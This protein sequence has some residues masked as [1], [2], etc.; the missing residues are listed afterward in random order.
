MQQPSLIVAQLNEALKNRLEASSCMT[1]RLECQLAPSFLLAFHGQRADGKTLFFWQLEPG[2]HKLLDRYQKTAAPDAA[3]F[4]IDINL[5]H[6]SFIY[7]IISPQQ[8]AAQ[9]DKETREQNDE[10]AR[11]LQALKQTLLA[12]NIPYGSE[13]AEQV[14]AALTHGALCYNH[15]DYCG[16]GLEKNAGGNYVYAMIWDGW[17]ELVHTFATRQ[18]FVAWLAGQSDASLSRVDE[19]DTWVWNNQVIN[20]QRLEEFVAWSQSHKQDSND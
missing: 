6:N 13:L 7:S 14:A 9:K 5:A 17:M 15:R 18:A 19:P 3:A 20:R 10:Q 16:M 11:R 1:G 4:T 8:A 2:I 12:S